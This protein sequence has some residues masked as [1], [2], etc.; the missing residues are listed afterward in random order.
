[1]IKRKKHNKTNNPKVAAHSRH[2]ERLEGVRQSCCKYE[3]IASFHSQRRGGYVRSK[4]FTLVEMIVV[5]GV[6]SLLLVAMTE[7]FITIGS[8]YQSANSARKVTQDV[9]YALEAISREVRG[10]KSISVNSSADTDSN[11]IIVTT[12]TDEKII[13]WCDNCSDS[14]TSGAIKMQKNADAAQNV[15]STSSVVTSFEIDPIEIAKECGPVQP[16]FKLTITAESKK[17]DSKGNKQKV[18]LNTLMSQRNYDPNYIPTVTI[19]TS[20]TSQTWMKCN[21]NVGTMVAGSVNQA[22]GQKY[23]YDNDEKNCN[24]Y[25]GLYQWNTAMNGSTTE[26]DQ[27]ICPAGFHVPKDSEWYALENYL[28]DDGN[29]CSDIRVGVFD[30]SSAGTKLKLTGDSGFEGF[31]AGHRNCD[32][33]TF[34]NPGPHGDYWSSTSTVSDAWF[35]LLHADYSTVIRNIADKAHG[36]SV[37]CLKG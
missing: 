10:A 37:R 1:M 25:G 2:C 3:E 16:F 26:G 17:A 33:G 28:K 7:L 4:G 23:C 27:G 36:H 6:M 11:K 8:T 15:V 22:I 32:D 34:G 14:S 13:F 9:R 35:R 12:Q 20:P 18:S 5:I 29:T 24:I 31:L 19:N 21:M 30:C